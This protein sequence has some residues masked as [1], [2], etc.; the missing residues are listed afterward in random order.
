MKIIETLDADG[1]GLFSSQACANVDR[2]LTK[3]KPLTVC[4]AP[5]Q[6]SAG[7]TEKRQSLS[8]APVR[9]SG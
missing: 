8:A 7:A 4:V 2:R 6:S 3:A 5:P 9:R 1:H